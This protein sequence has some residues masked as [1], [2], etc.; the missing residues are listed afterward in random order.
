MIRMPFDTALALEAL[1][2]TILEDIESGRG[3]LQDS[4]PLLLRARAALRS[5]LE[6]Y[7]NGSKGQIELVDRIA[8]L[9]KR[10][11]PGNYLSGVALDRIRRAILNPGELFETEYRPQRLCPRCE[12]PIH[13]GVVTCIGDDD[14]NL[15]CL[16][17]FKPSWWLCSI[18]KAPVSISGTTLKRISGVTCKPCEERL[19]TG[20]GDPR[21]TTTAF[22][23]VDFDLPSE[24]PSTPQAPGAPTGVQTRTVR[25][26]R[27]RYSHY[28]GPP[29]EDEQR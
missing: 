28:G 10:R 15:F 2:E 20:G 14:E 24:V 7:R 18:C 27:S 9:L 23:G 8:H 22:G 17:C 26:P 19:Q 16:Q 11:G 13:I 1:L 3:Q 6:D 29:T 12:T 5:Q 21:T 25:A 4:L